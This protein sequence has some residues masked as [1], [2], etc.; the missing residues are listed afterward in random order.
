MERITHKMR[1]WALL[2]RRDINYH[3]LHRE[4]QL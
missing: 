2:L 3:L 1:A 4:Q